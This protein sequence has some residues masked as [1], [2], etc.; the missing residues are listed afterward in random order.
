M[1]MSHDRPNKNEFS[2]PYLESLLAKKNLDQTSPHSLGYKKCYESYSMLDWEVNLDGADII[3]ISGILDCLH[4]S[5]NIL[6]QTQQLM[7]QT[8]EAEQTFF[9]S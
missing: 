3:K 1:K 5:Q 7:S 4:S 2:V 8:D 9:S 6:I